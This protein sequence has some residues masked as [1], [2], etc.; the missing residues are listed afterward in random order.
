F[1]GFQGT[2]QI[3]G[4]DRNRSSSNLV[5]PP[6]PEVRTKETLGP[7]FG[8]QAGRNGGV[9]IARD[10]SNIN[11]VAIALLN[12]RLPNGNYLIPSPQVSGLG[13]NY[14]VSIPAQYKEKQ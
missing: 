10:G 12:A 4:A 9:A 2:R 7:I 3:N 1:I 13:V 8:G 11:P 5:L 14:S 6:I